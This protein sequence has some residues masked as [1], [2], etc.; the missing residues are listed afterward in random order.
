MKYVDI[1]SNAISHFTNIPEEF[2]RDYLENFVRSEGYD[3]ELMNYILDIDFPEIEGAILL[4]DL[5]TGDL[6]STIKFFSN[7]FNVIKEEEQRQAMVN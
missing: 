1:F 5:K 4:Q 2:V 3:T 7:S 6:Q